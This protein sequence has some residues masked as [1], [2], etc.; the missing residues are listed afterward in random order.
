[1]K[2]FYRTLCKSIG[3]NGFGAVDVL[4]N[5]T[6]NDGYHINY[7]REHIKEMKEAI[8]DGV[9]LIGYTT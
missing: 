7:F 2:S 4:E 8:A 3:E 6:V 1:M 9:D 5:D